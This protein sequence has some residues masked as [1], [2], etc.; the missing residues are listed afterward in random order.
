MRGPKQQAVMFLLGA[1]L[2]GGALGF[3]ADRVMLS[4]RI[5]ISKSKNESALDALEQRLALTPE[6][7][8]SVEAILD[9]RHRQYQAA[10][11]PIRPRLDSI[12]MNARDQIRRVLTDEQRQEFE[13]FLSSYSDSTKKEDHRDY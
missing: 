2:V 5:C 9:D 12:K 3:T 10:W 1:L 11:K 13:L 4:D 8:K 7:H 6:Q